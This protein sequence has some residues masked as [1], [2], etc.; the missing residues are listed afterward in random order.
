MCIVFYIDIEITYNSTCVI[1]ICSHTFTVLI[2]IIRWRQ[3]LISKF[4][5]EYMLGTCILPLFNYKDLLSNK[6]YRFFHT[7]FPKRIF[8]G[9][10]STI[11]PRCLSL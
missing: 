7:G 9:V 2:T 8:N 10:G 4:G 1:N 5:F 3:F 11:K 6:T